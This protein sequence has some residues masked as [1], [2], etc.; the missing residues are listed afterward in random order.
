VRVGLPRDLQRR[1]VQDCIGGKRLAI[2]AY[3]CIQYAVDY[4]NFGDVRHAS[5]SIARLRQEYF[6]GTLDSFR[7]FHLCFVCFTCPGMA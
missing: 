7:L 6:T 5:Q 1:I 4:L 2:P 3:R